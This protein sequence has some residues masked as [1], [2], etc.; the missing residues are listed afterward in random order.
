MILNTGGIISLLL[1]DGEFEFI[2]GNKHWNNWLLDDKTRQ[3]NKKSI[4]TRQGSWATQAN[5]PV[6]MNQLVSEN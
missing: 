2:D 5:K 6:K 1:Y 4:G 3:P